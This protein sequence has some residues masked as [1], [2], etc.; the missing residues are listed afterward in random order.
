[1]RPRDFPRIGIAQPVVRLL[2]L[3][4]VDDELLENPV[5]VAQAVAHRGQA[6]RRHRIE[7]AGR[8]APKAAIAKTRIRFLLDDIAPVDVVLSRHFAGDVVKL[9][10]ADIVAQRTADQEF[11]RKIVDALGVLG[12]VGAPRH[13]PAPGQDIAD[14]AGIGFE[15]LAGCAKAG[16]TTL[17]KTRWRS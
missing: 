3:P 6:H 9:Q 12:V 11:H 13:H 1:M 16:S 5:F 8:K 14:R 15:A 10:I 7:E 2:L 17:S 4:A